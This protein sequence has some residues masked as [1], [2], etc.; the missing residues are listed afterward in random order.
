MEPALSPWIT[1]PLTLAAMLAVSA[2]VTITQHS[3]APASRKRIRV[4]NG[5]VMLLTLPLFAAGI[6]FVSAESQPRLFALVWLGVVGL[7]V[8]SITLAVIDALN[9]ARITRIEKQ[10]QLIDFAKKTYA[11]RSDE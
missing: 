5:W 4:A 8:L 6:S 1:L 3:P 7:L 2:H 10:N 9:T 11:E